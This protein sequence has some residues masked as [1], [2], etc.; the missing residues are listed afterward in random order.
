MKFSKLF[1]IYNDENVEEKYIN[2]EEVCQYF[3]KHDGKVNKYNLKRSLQTFQGGPKT[4]CGKDSATVSAV[5]KYCFSYS[6]TSKT[7]ASIVKNIENELLSGETCSSINSSL[8]LYKQIAKA[9]FHQNSCVFDHIDLNEEEI[10]TLIVDHKSYFTQSEWKKICWFENSFAKDIKLQQTDLSYEA[11]LELKYNKYHSLLTLTERSKEWVR[12][13]EEEILQKSLRY[14]ASDREN[15]VKL[16]SGHIAIILDSDIKSLVDIYCSD[17]ISKTVTFDLTNGINPNSVCVVLCYNQDVQVSFDDLCSRIFYMLKRRHNV[18]LESVIL[19]ATEELKD[20]VSD[21]DDHIYRFILRDSVETKQL[22]NIS[23]VWQADQL[24]D[25]TIDYEE[26][27]HCQTCYDGVLNKPLSSDQFSI[28]Q[29][30]YLE[31]PIETQILLENF[32][33]K[34]TIRRHKDPENF[35]KKKL[36]KLY[37]VYDVLLNIHNKKFTGVFQKSNS[38]KLLIEYKS[39][40]SVFDITYATGTTSSLSQAEA[41][42]KSNTCK[43]LCYYN[44]YLKQHHLKYETVNK[45]LNS[46][47]NLRSCHLI[48]MLDNLVR[49]QYIA[50]PNPGEHR[51][52]QLCTLPIT[53]QGLPLDS[54]ITQQWHLAECN[55]QIDCSCKQPVHL[56]K[57]D[58]ERVLLKNDEDQQTLYSSFFNLLTFGYPV[59]WKKLPGM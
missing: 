32:I 50:D 54:S 6:N 35:I 23:K 52:K 16:E 13:S 39:V 25:D 3:Q 36:Q 20:Y 15:Q 55:G 29:E 10:A 21:D 33:N 42:I 19:I 57:D 56:K 14:K 4:I 34:D 17:S 47:I 24:I 53:L 22:K 37:S 27:F 59:L 58:I 51:S 38:S 30:W 48:L 26:V 43:D 12:K 5:L 28:V 44:T 18:C 40:G 11:V 8:E 45:E 46:S 31:T 41:Q 7:C 1:H 49:L 2:V 9:K